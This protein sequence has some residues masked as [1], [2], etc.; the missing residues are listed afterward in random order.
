MRNAI[1][2]KASITTSVVN[3]LRTVS[4]LISQFSKRSISTSRRGPTCVEQLELEGEMD[5]MADA[6]IGYF[7]MLK[8]H[9][10]VTGYA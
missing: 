5:L 6:Q 10:H 7:A 8:D 2:P 9:K 4:S 3:I 1:N